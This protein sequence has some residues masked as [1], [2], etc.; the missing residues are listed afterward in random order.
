[1]GAVFAV[2]NL[3]LCRASVQSTTAVGHSV[4]ERHLFT[5]RTPAICPLLSAS[6][7][8]LARLRFVL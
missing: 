3:Y 8:S 1:M 7:H 2:G 5:F 4:V 6:A